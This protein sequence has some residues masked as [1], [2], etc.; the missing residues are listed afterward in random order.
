MQG[1][2]GNIRA[3]MGEQNQENEEVLHH[4]APLPRRDQEASN[5]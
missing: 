4:L 1:N 2:S 3:G 5:S